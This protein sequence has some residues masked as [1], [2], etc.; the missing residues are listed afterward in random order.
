MKESDFGIVSAYQILF[1][2]PRNKNSIFETKNSFVMNSAENA[3][4]NSKVQ[5][6]DF[7]LQ[8][9]VQLYELPN[10]VKSLS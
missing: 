7:F 4:R 9:A 1:E 2:R 5:L 10:E 8:N 6:F 3:L